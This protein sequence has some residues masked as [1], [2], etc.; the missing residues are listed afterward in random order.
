MLQIVV[1]H[2]DPHSCI[3]GSVVVFDVFCIYHCT[4][5]I[6]ACA[7]LCPLRCVMLK[8]AQ[9]E[10]SIRSEFRQTRKL[11]VPTGFAAVDCPK[12]ILSG[13]RDS[14]CISN[15]SKTVIQL[16]RRL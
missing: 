3:G 1:V 7:P 8:F 6:V 4:K 15:P 14:C 10:E 13:Q 11:F 9:F 2:G 12:V 5:F 16:T